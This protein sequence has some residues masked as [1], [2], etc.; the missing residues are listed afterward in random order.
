MTT[1]VYIIDKLLWRSFLALIQS[2]SPP[3]QLDIVIVEQK[4]EFNMWAMSLM[5]LLLGEVRCAHLEVGQTSV[6]VLLANLS[7]FKTAVNQRQKGS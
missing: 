7:A 6:E 2:I 1:I 4:L 5:M 3:K